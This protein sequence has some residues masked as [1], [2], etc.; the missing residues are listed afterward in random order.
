M[1]LTQTER[2]IMISEWLKSQIEMIIK[3]EDKTNGNCFIEDSQ[4]NYIRIETQSL[5]G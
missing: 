1:T 4:G 5:E 2:N 3:Q